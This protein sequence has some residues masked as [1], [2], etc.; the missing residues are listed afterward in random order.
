M[1]QIAANQVHKTERKLDLDEFT[2]K[3][4][5]RTTSWHHKR[6]QWE[7]GMSKPGNQ[8]FN[9]TFI[10]NEGSIKTC[11]APPRQKAITK[12]SP[13]VKSVGETYGKSPS[14]MRPKRL[15]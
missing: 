2:H 3:V 4:E 10:S 14:P 15:N 1:E 7:A 11:K 12:D 5:K 9:S 6:S 8:V 13:P